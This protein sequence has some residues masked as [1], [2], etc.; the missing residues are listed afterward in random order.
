MAGTRLQKPT[1]VAI[2]QRP[3]PNTLRK[4]PPPVSM[5]SYPSVCKQPQQRPPPVSFDKNVRSSPAVPT[6]R[7][8]GSLSAVAKTNEPQ[9]RLYQY[10]APYEAI[11]SSLDQRISSSSNSQDWRRAQD[12]GRSVDVVENKTA[13]SSNQ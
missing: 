11:P 4:K 3:P 7:R 12:R 10:Y 6:R 9:H 13:T 8:H 1:P 5:H 2:Q